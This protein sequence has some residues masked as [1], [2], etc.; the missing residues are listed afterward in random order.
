MR[1]KDRSTNVFWRHIEKAHRKYHDELKGVHTNQRKLIQ[2]DFLSPK[3]YVCGIT[4][5]RT[6][7]EFVRFI[8]DND[9]PWRLVKKKSF[10]R[11]WFYGTQL[12]GDVPGP[13][14]V[15]T[16]ASTM[17]TEVR[18]KLV[19]MFAEI[20]S[21]SL[22]VDAWTSRNNLS[23]LGVTAHWIDGD[24]KL[25]D[26]LLAILRIKGSHCDTNL[27]RLIVELAYE[28]GIESKLCAITTDNA[29]NNRT[30]MASIIDQRKAPYVAFVTDEHI[31]S[32]GDKCSS[33][34]YAPLGVAV[35]RVRAII[36]AIQGSTQRMEKYVD[37]CKMFELPNS[38]KIKVD[39]PTHWNST[40]KMLERALA[41]REVLDHVAVRFLSTSCKDYTL[42][43][44]DWDLIEEY[45]SILGPLCEGSDYVCFVKRLPITDVMSLISNLKSQLEQAMYSAE[46]TLDDERREALRSACSAMYNKLISMQRSFGAITQWR[47]REPWIHSPR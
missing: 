28:Y 42:C 45:L 16:T 12:V 20:H 25:C 2:Y 32:Q 8:C 3:L 22:T 39:C 1:N 31:N 41:K 17:Y 40:F 5:E 35:S 9:L 15:K 7:E 6:K 47:R 43:Q 34:T 26:L 33:T 19:E 29:S 38:N 46:A 24:W 23:L 18:G 21:V 4:K 14:A 30:M 36:N 27:A 11:L 37:M 13:D 10:Q 44:E